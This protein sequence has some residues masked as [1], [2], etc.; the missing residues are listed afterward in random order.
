M[1]D[2]GRDDSW[3]ALQLY[4]S[5][6]NTSEGDLRNMAQRGRAGG[7]AQP[8]TATA[9]KKLPGNAA[10]GSSASR[11]RNLDDSVSSDYPATPGSVGAAGSGGAAGKT[12]PSRA[13]RAANR[14][15]LRQQQEGGNT[16]VGLMMPGSSVSMVQ[17]SDD[18]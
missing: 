11:K 2:L 13:E 12:L 15:Q 8:P 6:L 14:E 9:L 7:A 3:Y 10:S 1:Y 17:H 4:R 16:V 5:N 18:E